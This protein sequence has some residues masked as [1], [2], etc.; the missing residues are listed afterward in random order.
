MT[1]LHLIGGTWCA[2]CPEQFSAKDA[3]TGEPLSTPFAEANEK[4]VDQA[5]RLAEESFDA[6]QAAPRE[7]IAVLLDT[8]AAGIESADESLLERTHSETG[9]PMQRL[10]MER[11]RTV[12]QT[13]RFAQLVREG[14]WVQARIDR[15]N[16]GRQPMPKPDVR[17]MLTGI[18]PVAVFGASNFPLAISVAGT[19]TISA[20]AARCP[21]VVKG[22]PGHPGTCEWITELIAK[23][24]SQ[25]GLPMGMFSMLQGAGHEVGMALVRHPLTQAVAFTGS[26]RGGRAL[27]NEAANR[28]NPIPVY[29]EM[30]SINP[31]FVL[32]DALKSRS[33]QIARDYVQ[34]VTLGT[35]QFCTNPGLLFVPT[36]PEGDQFVEQVGSEA[37]SVPPAPM[38]HEGILERYQ[39][40]V[41]RMAAMEGVKRIGP[42]P[43]NDTRQAQCVI[44]EANAALFEQHQTLSE[45]V[46]GPASL[47][48]RC[49]GVEQ[50]VEIARHLQGQLTA[51]IHG[52]P[53]ELAAHTNLIHQL[54]RH[55][56]RLVFNGFP[57]GI[58]VCA[59]MHHGGPYPATTHCG[60]TSIGDAAILRFTRPICYQN[61]PDNALPVE[62]QNHNASGIWRLVDGEFSREDV[63]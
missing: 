21:V 44:F 6:L 9:L 59:A 15:G 47:V 17:A 10:Q 29:A 58:E 23:S 41:T 46:F 14:S 62:L 37:A 26:L 60:F 28:P 61:L 55:V 52:E 3:A 25:V 54:Q 56:G 45:E 31:V 4:D 7:Q 18:G 35:G 13:R 50:M 38:L 19:D 27:F 57:T 1:G 51:S 8:I 42:A 43:T 11:A 49:E 12:G 48:L 33:P 53:N 24:I 20:F 36:G 32:P 16:P 63:K 22:H 34:S 30:G 40:G 5:M 39:A 2:D